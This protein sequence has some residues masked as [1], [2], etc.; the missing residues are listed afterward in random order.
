M[1]DDET[2]DQPDDRPG[3]HRDEEQP[4]PGRDQDQPWEKSD[5]AQAADDG[6]T[7]PAPPA[8][9]VC[10]DCGLPGDRYPTWTNTWVLLEPVEPRETL[11]A[12]MVPARQRWLIDSDGHAWN[13]H[14]AEPT[15]GAEC[16]I[17]HRLVCPGLHG[18]ER[19]DPWPWLTVWRQENERRAQRKADEEG[20]GPWPDA[21]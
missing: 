3:E 20:F 1:G 5:R 16:R 9:P 7:G 4:G 15:P 8:P 13:T 11:P 2:H 19:P 17:A 14:D 6:A 10:P 21:G 18:S 12:H